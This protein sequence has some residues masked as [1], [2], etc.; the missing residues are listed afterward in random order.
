M[1]K[2]VGWVARFFWAAFAAAVVFRHVSFRSLPTVSQG[3]SGPWWSERCLVVAASDFGARPSV[4]RR[5]VRRKGKLPNHFEKFGKISKQCTASMWQMPRILAGYLPIQERPP[6]GQLG[7]YLPVVVVRTAGN[8]PRQ[9]FSFSCAVSRFLEQ[10]SPHLALNSRDATEHRMRA[11][12]RIGYC[13]PF[14][15]HWGFFR[16]PSAASADTLH[17]LRWGRSPLSVARRRN[18]SRNVFVP[19]GIRS[20]RGV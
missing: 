15:W 16:Y 17:G 7:N 14:V 12:C 6:H 5:E 19:D 2:M 9:R 20:R 1:G 13:R 8:L 18:P 4:S 3:L 11:H 10:D